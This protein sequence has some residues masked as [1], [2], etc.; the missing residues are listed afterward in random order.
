VPRDGVADA[1]LLP[2]FRPSGARTV[3]WQDWREMVFLHWPVSPAALRARIPPT[4]ELDLF[5]G[6]AWVSLLP[7]AIERARPR[8]VPAA[9]GLDFLEVNLRTYVLHRGE[10]GIWFFSLD[11]D[12]RVAVA[13]ARVG[14]GLPYLLARIDG[15]IEG[16]RITYT[17]QRRRGPS[18][19]LTVEV[20]AELGPAAFGTLDWFL[21]ER[22]V[23]FVQR[24]RALVREQIH[25]RPYPLGSA[26]VLDLRERLLEAAGLGAVSAGATP[27]AHYSPGVDVE[28][29]APEAV[30][31]ARVGSDLEWRT[32]VGV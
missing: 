16:N 13:G 26:R 21:L 20:G 15:A 14:L 24:R 28:F 12:S 2:T 18:M 4:L 1:R 17:C 9:L 11:A 32:P 10:P 23:L 5:D 19:A 6:Q 30:D 31:R 8:G 25:H 7:F 29:F 27:L 22:Y 3:G